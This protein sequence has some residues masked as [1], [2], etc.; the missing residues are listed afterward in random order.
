MK[1]LPTAP[2][3]DLPRSQRSLLQLREL[4]PHRMTLH[5]DSQK[6][7]TGIVLGPCD[8]AFGRAEAGDLDALSAF[9]II[10]KGQ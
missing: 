3:E 4:P 1:V 8:S 9:P 7:Q 6:I 5:Q 10:V 2:P